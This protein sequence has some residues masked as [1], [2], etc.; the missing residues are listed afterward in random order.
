MPRKITLEFPYQPP[1]E[2]RGNSRAHWS[3]RNRAVKALRE[4]TYARFL[5]ICVNEMAEGEGCALV[6]W[7]RARITY[8]SYWCG[9]PID[10]DNLIIG[11]KPILDEIITYGILAD[12]SPKYLDGIDVRYVRVAHREDIRVVVEVEEVGA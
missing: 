9:K 6:P 1:P 11:C 12:D 3:K 7:P 10:E 8:T 5:G 2:L 4:A